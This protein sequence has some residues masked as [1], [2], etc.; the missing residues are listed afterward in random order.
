[1][2]EPERSGVCDLLKHF[3]PVSNVLAYVFFRFW[4]DR[5]QDA[6]FALSASDGAEFFFEGKKI[7][8]IE[9]V[10]D[11]EYIAPELVKVQLKHGYNMLCAKVAEGPTPMQYRQAWGVRALCF[12]Q[13]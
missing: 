12:T 4:S 1:M 7:G 3:G 8:E 5:E 2:I 11:A 6:E 9:P 13:E 10:S